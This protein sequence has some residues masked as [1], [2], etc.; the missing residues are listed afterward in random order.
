MFQKNASCTGME[1]FSMK[2]EHK[3]KGCNQT[4]RIE[5]WKRNVK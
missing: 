5:G 1:K 4:K 3:D 2:E